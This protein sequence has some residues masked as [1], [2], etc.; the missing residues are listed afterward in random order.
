MR[1]E[2]SILGEALTTESPNF[3]IKLFIKPD[4]R[5]KTVTKLR[6]KNLDQINNISTELQFQNLQQP[7]SAAIEAKTTSP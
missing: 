2:K 5:L 3:S 4:F 6:L 7:S 1:I